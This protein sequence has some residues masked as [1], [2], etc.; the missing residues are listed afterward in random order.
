M[1][2]SKALV[3]PE[4]LISWNMFV[5]GNVV[6]SLDFSDPSAGLSHTDATTAGVEV[7][8]DY[9]IDSHFLVGA[10]FGY[11]HTDATLDTL[12]SKASVDTYAPGVYAS[13]SEGGW[14]ANALGSY[15]FADY[16][17]DRKVAIGAFN[18]DAYSSPGGD[19]IVGNLDGGY[20]FHRNHWTFGPT[21]GVQYVHLDVDGFT[22]T[23]L[24]GAPTS[25]ST[26]T[27][28]TPLAQPS[29]R[30][31]QLHAVQ[32]GGMTF[33]PHL[34]ASWQHEFLDQSRGITS[35]FNDIGA[36]S[37]LPC[38]RSPSEHPIPP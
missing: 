27:K 35:Q 32:D 33:T 22:E 16:D 6:L 4:S 5:S 3:S 1:K 17:Q 29:G 21:L 7:G 26:K 14:Y 15:G 20:D 8:A 12:G 37:C 30:T 36:G 18:G 13:Y 9:R 24:P 11:G 2:E 10:M 19:Q 34:S 25:T 38:A 23:G 28:A 31:N